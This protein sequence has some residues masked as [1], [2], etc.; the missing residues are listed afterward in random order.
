MPERIFITYTNA[1]AIPYQGS[2]WAHHAVLNYIDSK[3]FHHTLEG[4]P[5]HKFNRNVEKLLATVREE[6]FSSG[7]DNTDSRFQRLRAKSETVKSDGAATGPRTMIA[8][9][10]DLSSA[11]AKMVRFGDEVNSTGYEYR[12]YSQ[13]S[14]SFAAAA[15]KHA[16][17][18]GPGTAFPE[19]S[20]RLIAF[21]PVSGKANP[22]F[23]TG[24]DRR[25][26]NPINRP[27]R[28]PVQGLESPAVPS[29]ANPKHLRQNLFNGRFGIWAAPSDGSL[30][31][32]NPPLEIGRPVV[33]GDKP[34]RYLGRRIADKSKASAFVT[35]SP[36]V[37]LVPSNNFLSPDTKTSLNDR[38]DE[39][40]SLVAPSNLDK[41]ISASASIDDA[42]SPDANANRRFL[43]RRVA[44][45]PPVSVFDTG[46]PAVSFAPVDD[47]FSP[48]ALGNQ[49]S[50]GFKD[51][52]GKR[53]GDAFS[54]D[55]PG[56]LAARIA[57][58]VGVDSANSETR[59]LTPA[60]RASDE[61]E[62][63]QPWLLRASTG[64]R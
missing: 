38:L 26:T 15:L 14:N 1:T 47:Y 57:A 12:P 32:P 54:P 37:P 44:G 35:R 53:A 20:E 16:G 7:A 55:T 48:A 63:P 58:L 31:P 46:A 34:A 10:D 28:T 13:N 33:T 42:K 8:E 43:V 19:F 29:E 24:F 22:A 6:A 21:D 39:V 45:R 50:T 40:F 23:V 30:D 41:R 27:A 5:K 60:R 61:A 25:L 11:W 9:G 4:M 49:P 64:L 18:F 3:G 36:A 62:L 17:F 56:G 2:A 52:R 59:V 51:G